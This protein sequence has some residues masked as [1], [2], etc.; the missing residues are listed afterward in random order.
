MDDRVR[1][2]LTL[3][4]AEAAHIAAQ[5]ALMSGLFASGARYNACVLAAGVLE[6]AIATVNA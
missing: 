6:D 4:Q 2:E 5:Y 3:E 1:I